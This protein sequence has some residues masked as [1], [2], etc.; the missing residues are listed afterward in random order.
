MAW[1]RKRILPLLRL[2]KSHHLVGDSIHDPHDSLFICVKGLY[3]Q[4]F[5]YGNKGLCLWLRLC[6]VYSNNGFLPLVLNNDQ[7]V[8]RVHRQPID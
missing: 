7:S 4:R 2:V 6:D 8:L 3:K 1:V 5:V